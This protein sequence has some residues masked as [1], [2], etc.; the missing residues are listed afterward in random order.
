MEAPWQVVCGDRSA[1]QLLQGRLLGSASQL[2]FGGQ[3]VR[4]VDELAGLFG[5]QRSSLLNEI[6]N[7]AVSEASQ[8]P[9]SSRVSARH[10]LE[11][12]KVSE[13]KPVVK[14]VCEPLWD[15]WRSEERIT[16]EGYVGLSKKL[17]CYLIPGLS[18][19]G[20]ARIAAQMAVVDSEGRFQ[21]ISPDFAITLEQLELLLMQV[22]VAMTG[23]APSLSEFRR[24]LDELVNRLLG[25]N[26]S[27]SLPSRTSRVNTLPSIPISGETP[28]RPP[29]FSAFRADT[30]PLSAR[31][32]SPNS[33]TS[34]PQKASSQPAPGT[35]GQPG[36]GFTT[37]TSATSTTSTTT[38][39]LSLSDLSSPVLSDP[40]L[41][42]VVCVTSEAR[43]EIPLLRIPGQSGPNYT[44]DLPADV[45]LQAVQSLPEEGNSS[46]PT[47]PTSA[48]PGVPPSTPPQS[49]L[50]SS[51][52][53]SGTSPLTIPLPPP[54]TDPEASP[55]PSPT[56]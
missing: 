33:S 36:S 27:T 4:T 42:Y 46:E 51:L 12:A 28:T 18:S 49:Q 7:W 2:S 19:E 48:D 8:R 24:F 35:P 50:E 38:P 55:C 41:E 32:S 31:S 37:A 29:Q 3:P 47:S 5:F 22:G 21:A 13:L 34:S 53:H 39:S 15:A 10:R 30:A 9:S 16:A 17:Y 56:A 14:Q 40:T 43:P 25:D 6:Y 20:A 52:P 26:V 1:R 44:T 11:P 54:G 23:G 45:P